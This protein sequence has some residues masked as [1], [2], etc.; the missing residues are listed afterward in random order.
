MGDAYVDIDVDVGVGAGVGVD[1]VVAVDASDEDMPY[2]L[3]LCNFAWLSPNTVETN[4]NTQANKQNAP[5]ISDRRPNKN[6]TEIES[7]SMNGEEGRRR[8]SNLNLP[9]AGRFFKVLPPNH[10]W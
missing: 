4:R 2:C 3:G 5:K 7:A 6:P 8:S 1:V 10:N 9:V